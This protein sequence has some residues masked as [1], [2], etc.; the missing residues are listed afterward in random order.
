MTSEHRLQKQL[1][2][3]WINEGV[4]ID[5]E[6]HFLAAWEVMDDYRINS[7]VLG[8]GR[9]AIDF[10]LLDSRGRLL[11]VELK[12]RVKTKRESWAVLCQVTRRT[13]LLAQGFNPARLASAH[14]ACFSGRYG[15]VEARPTTLQVEHAR[16]FD[17][18]PVESIAGLP[19]RRVVA[20][21]DFSDTWNGVH[22]TFTTAS[23]AEIDQEIS[24]YSQKGWP[25][26]EF[27]RWLDLPTPLE[28]L[29][30][31]GISTLVVE[32]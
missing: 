23:R 18:Q 10:L 2:A 24:R 21:T 16:F 25:G 6:R 12:M 17:T 7:A 22:D 20:A 19:A 26:T 30:A 5:D 14:E 3:H 1:T 13:A 11:A 9:P 28:T 4:V 29:V 31:P 27:K 8:F 32:T 15:R